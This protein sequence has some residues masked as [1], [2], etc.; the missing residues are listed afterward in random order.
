MPLPPVAHIE[1]QILFAI[2]KV[3]VSHHIISF[4]S[5]S[6]R[7]FF[8]HFSIG[9]YFP[10]ALIIFVDVS[11][12]VEIYVVVYLIESLSSSYPDVSFLLGYLLLLFEKKIH[13]WNGIIVKIII[14]GNV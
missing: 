3:K 9:S 11:E 14:T 7:I 4:F 1:H 8:Y 12:L 5:I 10:E 2:F 13:L 6:F